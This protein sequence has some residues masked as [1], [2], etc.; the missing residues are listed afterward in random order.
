MSKK[1]DNK[2]VLVKGEH[3]RQR[4]NCAQKINST[5]EWM[6]RRDLWAV[7]R[8]NQT[9]GGV[10]FHREVS[11]EEGVERPKRIGY[12]LTPDNEVVV[13][14][15]DS[16]DQTTGKF[17]SL[18]A[19]EFPPMM[20]TARTS[21]HPQAPLYW[22]LPPNQTTDPKER[23]EKMHNLINMVHSI[24]QEAKTSKAEYHNALRELN[25][26]RRR[27]R[28][29]ERI[30][31]ELRYRLDALE[32]EIVALRHR[33]EAMNVQRA[34]DEAT[35]EEVLKQAEE[36]GRFR[37]KHGLEFAREVMREV[38]LLR[39]QMKKA[40]AR[41]EVEMEVVEKVEGQEESGE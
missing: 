13:E 18:I 15:L 31:E 14:E 30:N 39:Q 40:T 41:K 32:P 22:W 26:L 28:D 25:S 21:P 10:L 3:L 37:G 5:L 33:V 16:F 2:I 36:D 20:L 4:L 11:Y 6:R 9:Y 27:Y 24:D 38:H 7:L 17:E 1:T 34:R 23:E 8:G 12:V 19:G 29:E 35:L